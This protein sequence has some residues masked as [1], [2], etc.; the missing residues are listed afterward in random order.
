LSQYSKRF[1][2]GPFPATPELL[3]RLIA[4]R[5]PG[6]VRELENA[7]ESAVALSR[8]EL[9]VSLLPAPVS[10]SMPDAATA[11]APSVAELKDRVDAYERG[12]IVQALEASRNNRSQT[13]RAL[14]LARATLLS[15]L[16]KYGLSTGDEPADEPEGDST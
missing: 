12:L 2:V 4:Y 5:W 14:G 8:D 6:N 11:A 10:T 7:I 3:D 9:D 13:A 15:K 16:K 1:G